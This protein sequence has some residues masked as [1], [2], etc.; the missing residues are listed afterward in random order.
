MRIDYHDSY[1]R[2]LIKDNNEEVTI[3]D[4]SIVEYSGIY[5]KTI[6]DIVRL[7]EIQTKFIGK[8]TTYR[9]LHGVVTGIYI[10]PLYIWNELKYEWNKIINYKPP[11]TKYFLYPHLLA[12]PPP[13]ECNTQYKPLNFLDTVI[14]RNLDDFSHITNTFSLE[15]EQ[16][17][18]EI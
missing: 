17:I 16:E 1:S 13:N 3:N 5:Y 14:N 7:A 6:N 10:E 18:Q 15:E 2:T 4:G 8:V 9:S 12:L 11:K